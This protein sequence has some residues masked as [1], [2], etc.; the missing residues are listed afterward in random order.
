MTDPV[1]PK[2]G[3]V[4]ITRREALRRILHTSASGLGALALGD[5]LTLDGLAQ[6]SLPFRTHAPKA[7]RVIWMFMAGAPS[8][9]ELFEPKEVLQRLSGETLPP[10][11]AAGKRFAFIDGARAKLLGSNRSFQRHGDC[12]APVSELLPHIAGIVDKITFI[13]GLQAKEI[14]HGP[15]KL[16]MNTGFGQFGRPSCG[17][18]TLYGLGSEADDLPG[19]VVLQSGPR[20][21]RGGG[22]LWGNAFLPSS[23]AG[24]PFRGSG[25]PVLDLGN[26]AGIDAAEQA[27]FFRTVAN[28]DRARQTDGSGALPQSVAERIKTYELA[29]RMQSSTPDLV[30]LSSE[31]DSV[32][33]LYGIEDD[34]PSFAR[35]CLL[36]RRLVERGSRFVQLYHTDWDHH[37][38][39]NNH[40]GKPLEQRCR[41]VDQASAALVLDLE[42]RG[43]LEDT[44]V[45]W[46]GEFG[47]TPLGEVRQF[48]GR[49]H[50]IDAFTI[51]MAGGGMKQGFSYGE[52]DEIGFAPVS[53]RMDIHD[54]HAT[55]LHLLGI[56]HERLTF[57]SQGRDFRLTDVHG[58][59]HADLF[60]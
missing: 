49:D 34:S 31:P 56:D 6:S 12:G 55:I 18:W 50:H 57:R 45:I 47:R 54:L 60:A 2:L 46:G 25:D 42:Q 58:R 8:Q 28:L 9:F 40:L 33:K 21:P 29:H 5:R 52:T 41:E 30:D 36:A 51:W 14:N 44:L 32:R 43:L 19:F 22:P 20:G 48:I 10:S 7:K 39:G 13:R 1:H 15:A 27:D 37:G 23:V 4:P 24:T 17:S 16:F 26:P 35:N 53:G 59:V 3:R 38:D 11:L